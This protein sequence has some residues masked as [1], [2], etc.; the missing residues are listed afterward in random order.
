MRSNPQSNSL[1]DPCPRARATASESQLGEEKIEGVA[2]SVSQRRPHHQKFGE[3]AWTVSS[4]PQKVARKII[5]N[6]V[7]EN[8][9]ACEAAVR[10]EKNIVNALCAEFVAFHL[11]FM[12]KAKLTGN[13]GGSA[14]SPKE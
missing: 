7:A 14:S 6:A 11:R 8:V 10:G 13:L 9:V 3:M 1:L 4:A 2:M 5:R 12:A